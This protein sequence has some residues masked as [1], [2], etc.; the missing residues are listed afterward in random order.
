VR[1]Q[2]R[3][4]AIADIQA[5][6]DYIENVLKNRNAARR[7]KEKILQGTS[8]LKDHPQIGAALSGKYEDLDTAIRFIVISNRLVFYEICD[9]VIEVVRVLDE[10]TDYMALLFVTETNLSSL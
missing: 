5:A 6:A 9:D 7:F 2:Y 4:A 3:P 1:L 10:R 8:L